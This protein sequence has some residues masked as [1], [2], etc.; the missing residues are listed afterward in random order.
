MKKAP[1]DYLIVALD[2]SSE[3]EA[4]KI[5]ESL[6]GHI[7]YFKIGLELFCSCGPKIIEEVKNRGNKVFFDGK[8]LDIPNTVSKAVS[9]IVRQR[10]DMVNVHIMGGEEMISEAKNALVEAANKYNLNPPALLGVTILTSMNQETISTD[11]KIKDK[12]EDYVLH[13]TRLGIK[14]GLDGVV[15]SPNEAKMIRDLANKEGKKD[16]LIVTPGVRPVW[17][18]TNDQQRIS[19]P[20]DAILNGVSHIVVGRPITA[21]KDP[22]D[23]TKKIIEEIEEAIM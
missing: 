5:I 8:F 3:S 21:S 12:I 19:T 9:S 22:I 11:L 14:N 6:S 16:F 10:V 7:D 13:L 17:A 2:T 15:C 23:A 4:L 1:K 20:K 18:K